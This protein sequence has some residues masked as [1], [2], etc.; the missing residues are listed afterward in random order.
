[1]EGCMG[2][3]PCQSLPLTKMREVWKDIVGFEGRYQV[4][5][6]GRVKSLSF[7]QRYL[8]RNGKEAF[9]R[10]RERIRKLKSINSG[11]TTV[12]LWLD[13]VETTALVHRLVAEAF[14][15]GSGETV[16]HKDGNKQNNEASNLEWASYTDNH[17]HAVRTG[18]NKQAIKVVCPKTGMVYD[19]IAQ[20]SR[21]AKVAHQTISTKWGRA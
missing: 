16:N 14:V 11:Y 7:M 15:E 19:S 12:A 18:L 20:A 3:L 13:D 21:H 1:M 8:L 10:T 5:N 17:L 4:S 6:L 9:R 2:G